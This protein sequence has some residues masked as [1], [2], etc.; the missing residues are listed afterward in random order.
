MV[1][2][3]NRE[4]WDQTMVDLILINPNVYFSLL[5]P[6]APPQVPNSPNWCTC[7][8]CR[9][10]PTAEESVCCGMRPETCTSESQLF[11]LLCLTET[12]LAI[13]AVSRN[14]FLGNPLHLANDRNRELRCCSYRQFILWQYGRISA[15]Q[16]GV[17]PSCCVWKIRTKF[18]D[19][20]DHYVGFLPHR[21]IN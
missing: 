7:G 10:M 3:L 8:K 6:S 12:I 19:V 1:A 20:N 9:P 14:D 18:P 5:P 11:S 4:Q 16:R 13:A 2:A 21:F 15:G 17:I